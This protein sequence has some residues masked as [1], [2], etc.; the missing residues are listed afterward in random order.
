MKNK[1]LSLLTLLLS[2][3][4]LIGCSDDDNKVTSVQKTKLDG[5]VEKGPFVNG[6]MVTL[7]ELDENLAQTGKSF[8]ATT[9]NEGRFEI[10]SSMAFVSPY[11]KV[12][13]TGFYYNEVNGQLSQA[14]ITLETLADITNKNSVNANLITH[15]EAKRVMYL[16]TQEGL[17]FSEA[18]QQAQKE[19]L[20]SFL[21]KDK[22]IVPETTTITGNDTPANILIAV[23]SILLRS[24]EKNNQTDAQFTELINNFRD[25][26]EKDG[27]ISDQFKEKIQVASKGLDYIRVKENIMDRY[28]EL[29]KEVSVGNFHY[30]IDGDGDGVLSDSDYD[31]EPS[32]TYPIQPTPTEVECK[33]ILTSSLKDT[34]YVIRN[35]Y[36][37]EALFTHTITA[38]D[39]I[40]HLSPI[41]DHQVDA[42]H[43]LV[44]SMWSDFYQFIT[45]E[46]HVIYYG[47]TSS[48]TAIRDYR[49]SAMVYR[50]YK[51]LHMVELWG[52]VPFITKPITDM[53][54]DDIYPKRTSKDQILTELIKELQ[55]AEQ[56]LPEKTDD[57][58]PSKYLATALLARIYLYQKDYKNALSAASRIIEG[59]QYS[60]CEYYSLNFTDK[61]NNE[62]IYMFPPTKEYEKHMRKGLEVPMIRYAEILLI[63]AEA[64]L[65]LGNNQQATKWV[66]MLRERNNRELVTEQSSSNIIEKAILEEWQNDLAI[67]AA[68]FN[69]L[70]RF[71]LAQETLQIPAYMELLPIPGRE[72]MSNPNMKQ[73]PG[74]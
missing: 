24:A 20:S 61:E 9:D 62:A 21:I 27:E 44:E 48:N 32:I 54:S 26:F 72:L 67:E 55:E 33:E 40:E 3:S 60:L 30:F 57:V 31:I 63:A 7:Y 5:V 51:Y 69:T 56:I 65:K 47:A 35:V 50:A 1:Y 25:D 46:N 12:T 28:H 38:S 18:K 66:N 39:G 4:F 45:R 14:Q 17:P 6:S 19:L 52:D 74:Y 16:V 34:W 22:T 58:I 15:L 29:E 13:V 8:S 73:N 36:L 68:W 64:E 49:I 71:G 59:G 11:I 42:H 70:K 41:Y 2:V 53:G 43:R 10:S 37:Y 23:S